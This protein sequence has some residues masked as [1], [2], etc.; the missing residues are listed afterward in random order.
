VPETSVI[1][2]GP[3]RLWV[4]LPDVFAMHW[5]GTVEASDIHA[6]YDAVA[7]FSTS[8]PYIFAF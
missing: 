6:M 4:E 1:S 7:H 5:Q 2:V 3:H 8:C